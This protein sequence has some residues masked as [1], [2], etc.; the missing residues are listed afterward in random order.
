MQIAILLITI[1]LAMP[2]IANALEDCSRSDFLKNWPQQNRMDLRQILLT[3]RAI[4]DTIEYT[5]KNGLR[6]IG[7]GTWEDGLTGTIYRAINPNEMIED[8]GDATR[9]A[10]KSKVSELLHIDHVIPLQWA[11]NNGAAAWSAKKKKAFATDERLLVITHS[12]EN[13][14]KGSQG[15]EKWQPINPRIAC[16][17]NTRFIYGILEYRFDV[18]TVTW[19]QI[20]ENQK[21]SC[22]KAYAS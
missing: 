5:T 18:P 13:T 15:A 7:R 17:Y 4:G 2:T 1:G 19:K 9:K 16:W 12:S 22:D 10:G 11:C 3:E 6:R 14:S 21:S 8:I 20:L